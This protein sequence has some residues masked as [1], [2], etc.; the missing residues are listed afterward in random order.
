ML[1]LNA[2][3]LGMPFLTDYMGTLGVQL[4]PY[5][6]YFRVSE[7][8]YCF[9]FCWTHTSQYG[10]ITKY[11]AGNHS[12]TR[13]NSISDKTSS[14]NHWSVYNQASLFLTL[15]FCKF[16]KP[17]VFFN[18]DSAPQS[19]IGKC[20]QLL[21]KKAPYYLPSSVFTKY[22]TAHSLEGWEVLLFIH[23]SKLKC[24]K[25]KEQPRLL[26]TVPFPVYWT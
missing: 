17:S 22:T 3:W 8:C 24:V 23:H 2:T 12:Y 11:W 15:L 21:R 9:R 4:S 1:L 20:A 6:Y 10:K 7:E 18:K 25:I 14:F 19:C 26:I 13:N 16:G 5:T